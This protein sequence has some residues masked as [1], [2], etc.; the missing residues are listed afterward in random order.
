ML[1]VNNGYPKA[2]VVV[3]LLRLSGAGP[4]RFGTMFAASVDSRATGLLTRDGRCP[5]LDHDTCQGTSRLGSPPMGALTTA[6]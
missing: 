1:L 3:S 2:E 5:R 4:T 6:L